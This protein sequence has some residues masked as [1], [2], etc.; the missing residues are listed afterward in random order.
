[1]NRLLAII[2]F[3]IFVATPAFAQFSDELRR[4]L[5]RLN[6]KSP[7]QWTKGDFHEIERVTFAMAREV[8]LSGMTSSERSRV[9]GLRIEAVDNDSGP[10]A[11]INGDVIRVSTAALTDLIFLGFLLGHDIYVYAGDD[12]PIRDTFTTHPYAASQIGPLL[13]PLDMSTFY[14]MPQDLVKCPGTVMKCAE[15]QAS[16]T[17][18]G[19]IGFVIAHEMAHRLL[20]HSNNPNRSAAEELAADAKAW[21][22]LMKVAPEIEADDSESLAYR[23]RIAIEAGPRMFL[24]WLV[25]RTGAGSLKEQYKERF[26]KISERATEDVDTAVMLTTDANWVGA[27]I[28]TVTIAWPESE[29]PDELFING[30]AVAPSEVGGKSLQLLSSAQVFARRGSRFAY[31]DVRREAQVRLTFTPLIDPASTSEIDRLRRDGKWFDVFLRTATPDLK[32]RNA[33]AARLLRDALVRM[34]MNRRAVLE[35]WRQMQ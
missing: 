3:C 26:D 14:R 21:D 24:R 6:A 15:P 11:S 19:V 29:R 16:A 33:Q 13:N 23:V 1:M 18:I 4:D 34:R 35:S 28:K 12:F 2:A 22:I 5:A 17:V 32:P 30:V 8:L 31:A 9:A 10:P 7:E 20:D 25:D 27:G